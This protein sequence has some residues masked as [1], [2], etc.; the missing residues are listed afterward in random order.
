MGED[1]QVFLGGKTLGCATSCSVEI[2]SD[3]IDISC[4]DTGQWGATKR[5]KM[6]WSAT[7]D[8]LMVVADYTELVDAMLAGKSLD[9]VF[10]TV[11]NK[12]K[13]TDPD[14]D[15]HIVPEGGWTSSND[16]Y[17]GKAVISSISMTAG[18]GELATYSVSFNGVG[19]LV[20]TT[21][22]TNG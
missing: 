15:G 17:S 16:M 13:T 18:N 5:G 14:D 20:K 21:A 6:S 19:A 3:D 9:F 11:A 4:K 10:A 7:S 12:D 22:S 1:I 8:N 2:N